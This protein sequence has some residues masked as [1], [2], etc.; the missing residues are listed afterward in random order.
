MLQKHGAFQFQRWMG[1]DRPFCMFPEGFIFARMPG[2]WQVNFSANRKKLPPVPHLTDIAQPC[3][4]PRPGRTL[5]DGIWG[6][7]S[8]YRAGSNLPFEHPGRQARLGGLRVF[9]GKISQ[10]A[11]PHYRA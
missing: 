3:R 2:G 11:N 10:A 7:P 4:R 9:L 5:L 6:R 8:K 1:V